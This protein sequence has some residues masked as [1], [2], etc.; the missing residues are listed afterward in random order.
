MPEDQKQERISTLEEEIQEFEQKLEEKKKE[1]AEKGETGKEEKEV[2]REVLKEH[3]RAAQQPTQSV[4]PPSKP[5]V[6]IDDDIKK[7][8]EREAEV[9]EL[10]EIA[11]TKTIQ[12]AVRIA[13]R[14]TPY[15]L[16]ELHDRLADDY[17]EKLVAL[18]KVKQF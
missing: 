9:R 5:A 8:E 16:D 3:I 4:T 12:E 7:R 17:Y 15:L 14:T 11:M 13:E 6:S 10:I 18:R 2:F 1:L